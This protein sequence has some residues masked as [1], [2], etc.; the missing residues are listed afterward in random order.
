MDTPSTPNGDHLGA[1]ICGCI[2]CSSPSTTSAEI[3][4]CWFRK[5]PSYGGEKRP[6]MKMGA[7]RIQKKNVLQVAKRQSGPHVPCHEHCYSRPA[8]RGNTLLVKQP[9][10]ARSESEKVPPV[11]IRKKKKRTGPLK[12]W[13]FF[14]PTTG[15]ILKTS[16]NLHLAVLLYGLHMLKLYFK[17]LVQ[18]LHMEIIW[19]VRKSITSGPFIQN[20]NTLPETDIFALKNRW[21][22]YYIVSF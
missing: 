9:S 16:A 6:K 12:R 19:K 7:N 2:I 8:A 20:Q 14:Q 1:M 11:V 3:T 13:P 21:L 17:N 10:C 18:Y 4:F 22:Q 15:A 5:M